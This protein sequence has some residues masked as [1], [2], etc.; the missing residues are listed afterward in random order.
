MTDDKTVR[1]IKQ[2]SDEDHANDEEEVEEESES[3][4]L[5]H[6]AFNLP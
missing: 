4:Q 1:S 3:T 5:H 2:G 6:E